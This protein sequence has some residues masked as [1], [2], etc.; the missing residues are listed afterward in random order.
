MYAEKQIVAMTWFTSNW[1]YYTLFSFLACMSSFVS[2]RRRGCRLYL[3]E[4]KLKCV[5]WC[6]FRYVG[7]DDLTGVEAM[8]ITHLARASASQTSH[9]NRCQTL[10]K[11]VSMRLALKC[12]TCIYMHFS[13]IVVEQWQ[14]QHSLIFMNCV[15][16]RHEWRQ[17][18]CTTMFFYMA[19]WCWILWSECL[20]LLL[21][22]RICGRQPI[23]HFK[24]A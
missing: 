16:E 8:H 21:A 13:E 22:H 20:L 9:I 18:Y 17:I 5:S 3:P 6:V 14:A 12:S 2:G 24:E 1:Y 10:C 4:H 19:I 7:L 11:L 15:C 23:C